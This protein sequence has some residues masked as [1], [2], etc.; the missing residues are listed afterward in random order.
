MALPSS[1]GKEPTLAEERQ[2][3][4]ALMAQHPLFA[5]L[6]SELVT[7]LASQAAVARYAEGEV[8]FKKGSKSEGICLVAE[9]EVLFIS[10]HESNPDEQNASTCEAGE[11]FG[12]LSLIQ[13][14]RRVSQ[15]R[16]GL[17]TTLYILRL[18]LLEKFAARHP[19][20]FA[21]LASNLARDLA[22]RLRELNTR[23]A[24]APSAP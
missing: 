8:I 10:G 21:V 14:R 1:R 22:R 19:D 9:G 3:C 5:W 13:P 6:K 12:E 17:D 24:T 4:R 23:R 18:G 7:Y 2:R 20:Q 11:V 15:A 16:A